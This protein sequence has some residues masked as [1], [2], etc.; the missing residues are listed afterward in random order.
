MRTKKI[1]PILFLI[2][3]LSLSIAAQTNPE[4]RWEI[5]ASRSYGRYHQ[6]G[7]SFTVKSSGEIIYFNKDKKRPVN[8]RAGDEQIKEIGEMLALLKLPAIKEIPDNKFNACIASLHLPAVSFI[9]KQNDKTYRLT[10]CN[11]VTGKS[12]YHYTLI[13]SNSQ[14]TTYETLRKKVIALFGDEMRERNQDKNSQTTR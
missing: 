3:G 1:F 13:L 9:L 10:H 8:G 4:S 6:S 14:K 2:F 12:P 5:V 7:E 11:L